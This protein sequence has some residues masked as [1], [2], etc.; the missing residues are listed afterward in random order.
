MERLNRIKGGRLPDQWLAMLDEVLSMHGLTRRDVDAVAL[1]VRPPD[2]YLK[3]RTPWR[4]SPSAP[5]PKS[6]RS[7]RIGCWS[8]RCGKSMWPDPSRV[9][10]ETISLSIRF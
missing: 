1:T 10:A 9:F 6:C 4:R 7:G 2:Y 8:T 5:S 3:M